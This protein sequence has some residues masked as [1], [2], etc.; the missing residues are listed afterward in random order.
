MMVSRLGF[1]GIPISMVMNSASFAKRLPPERFFAGSMSENMEKAANCTECGECED[2][3]PYDLPIKEII[4]ER[5]QWYREEKGKY[6]EA[7]ASR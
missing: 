3:C 6:Q 1:G 7:A 2:K 4:A 5:S